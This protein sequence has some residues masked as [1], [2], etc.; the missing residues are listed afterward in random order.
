MIDKP[1]ISPENSR[2]DLLVLNEQ[3]SVLI[4][5]AVKLIEE[6]AARLQDHKDVLQGLL[7]MA[8]PEDATAFDSSTMTFFKE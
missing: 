4:R 8:K 7:L 5:G 6:T 2:E 1:D 3:Q